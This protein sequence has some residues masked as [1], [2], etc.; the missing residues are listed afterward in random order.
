MTQKTSARLITM[1]SLFEDT[2]RHMSRYRDTHSAKCPE[3]QSEIN[4]SFLDITSHIDE[5]PELHVLAL[6]L[7]REA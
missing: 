5:Q 6:A 2:F 1:I 7:F 3:K 4:T